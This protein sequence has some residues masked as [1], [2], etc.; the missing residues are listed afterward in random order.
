MN[1]YRANLYKTHLIFPCPRCKESF[2]DAKTARG[3][4][5]CNWSL[6]SELIWNAPSGKMK[7][8]RTWWHGY[9]VARHT[10]VRALKTYGKKYIRC[11]FQWKKCQRLVRNVFQLDFLPPPPLILVIRIISYSCY[12]NKNS[13][14]EFPAFQ[15]EESQDFK[16]YNTLPEQRHGTPFSISRRWLGIGDGLAWDEHCDK[17]YR[18]RSGCRCASNIQWYYFTKGIVVKCSSA[19]IWD[20]RG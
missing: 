17:G 11:F 4:S 7:L 5:S 18:G 16:L 14:F 13:D 8:C 3:A 6:H 10:E 9:K 20:W 15:A 12:C 2:L 19:K 1:I